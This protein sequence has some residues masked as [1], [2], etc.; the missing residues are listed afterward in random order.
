MQKKNTKGKPKGLPVPDGIF[1]CPQLPKDEQRPGIH[2]DEQKLQW[3]NAMLPMMRDGYVQISWVRLAALLGAY[4]I[5]AVKLHAE[6]QAQ[7]LYHACTR[8]K[9]LKVVKRRAEEA[10][11]VKEPIP[12]EVVDEIASLSAEQVLIEGR[13]GTSEARDSDIARLRELRDRVAHLR[14]IPAPT[15]TEIRQVIY[16][17]LREHELLMPF[18]AKVYG[19]G[20]RLARDLLEDK[21]NRGIRLFAAEQA[22]AL[23]QGLRLI[24][25]REHPAEYARWQAVNRPRKAMCVVEPVAGGK[26]GEVVVR[27]NESLRKMI[28]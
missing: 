20:R 15:R 24:I 2:A 23:R 12:A 27:M 7:S 5:L 25:T 26:P 13:I 8:N 22:D 21:A 19:Q 9:K 3:A 11:E 28:K 17:F 18:G 6:A 10:V 1:E 14:S 4:E 16:I